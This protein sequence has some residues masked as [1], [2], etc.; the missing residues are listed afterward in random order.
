MT[1]LRT[2]RGFEEA[3]RPPI[4]IGRARLTPPVLR[5]SGPRSRAE[6]LAQVHRV[7]CRVPEVMV[8]VTGRTRD[9]GHLKAHLQYISRNGALEV[10][11]P[12]GE[13]LSGRAALEDQAQHWADEEAAAPRRRR[14]TPM[15][16]SIV[17]S[18]PAGTDALIVKNSARAFAS[19][20]FADRFDYVF[21]LHDEGRQPHVHLSVRNLGRNGERLNPRKADLQVWR[22]R[23]A[24]Q[25]RARGIEAEATPRRARGVVRKAEQIP[26]RKLR[27][28]AE[29][30]GGPL[31]LV[32]RKA[33][34]EAA[35]PSSDAAPWRDAIARRQ[36]RIRKLF[37]AEALGLT[38]S[39]RP[40][41][42]A[43]GQILIAA[44]ERWPA[45]EIRRDRLVRALSERRKSNL[46]PDR[47]RT[48]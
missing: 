19:E 17:L 9:G 41:E 27:D 36:A 22:E 34:A 31:P 21:A 4:D 28:R 8:K 1:D 13:S 26:V 7:A 24:H 2:L 18:M 6:I 48:R 11:G 32:L 5:R 3:L 12:N 14:D 33:L 20:I 23:F 44:I 43:L 40:M 29:R 37:Q 30:G 35:Y 45:P 47:D 38:R 15:S 10:E 46:G 16:V 42:R 25:L 39:D